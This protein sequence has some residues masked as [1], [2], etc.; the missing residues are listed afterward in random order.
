MAEDRL[1]ESGAPLRLTR[2]AMLRYGVQAGAALGLGALVGC[3]PQ[4]PATPGGPGGESAPPAQPVRT[5]AP[6]AKVAPGAG[7]PRMG[8]R[9]RFG[10]A[11]AGAN[12]VLDSAQFFSGTDWNFG[13]NL[14]DT[15]TEFDAQG[16]VGPGLA[17]SWDSPDPKT[18]VLHLREGVKFH[19]GTP[20]DAEAA[21]F[22][23]D[24]HLNPANKSRQVAQ[25]D[26]IDSV[27]V[28][29]ARTVR[30]HLKRPDADLPVSLA[31]A[32]GMM[33]SP[34]ARQKLGAQ[35]V[36]QPVG[37]GPFVFVEQVRD[38]H[39]LFRRN[40]Q[41][42]RKDGPY[43]DE[44]YHPIILDKVVRF[45]AVANG[46]MEFA[47]ARA[48]EV[49]S[50]R[51]GPNVKTQD[52]LDYNCGLF[53]MNLR[54]T[55]FGQNKYL[56]QAMAWALDR[57]GMIET[58]LGGLA[59][60]ATQLHPP[61]SFWYSKQ[62]QPYGYDPAR[63]RELLKQGGKPNGFK[64]K[65]SGPFGTP[66]V[67]AIVQV[68]QDQFAKVGI[69]TEMVSLESAKWLDD[70]YKVNYDVIP[71]I[72]FTGRIGIHDSYSSMFHT[73]GRFNSGARGDKELDQLIEQAV[74]EYD[75][76]KRKTM[77]DE[78]TRRVHDDVLQIF[79]FY[80]NIRLVMDK[81]VQ[82]FTWVPDGKT[83]FRTT[84]LA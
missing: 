1:A 63:A 36:N 22:N 7:E 57:K 74:G 13:Y 34:T 54:D 41:H 50:I 67:G 18:Y 4:A 24:Y 39:V 82:G 60:E 19:D 48:F 5:A 35:F 17:E 46:E 49:P 9:L 21:K 66:E 53:Y 10:V 33:V 44:L 78:I 15:L 40:E 61:F 56:R 47:V 70:L 64:F 65:M 43:L 80:S 26:S 59:V 51:M 31:D 12:P 27:E 58:L 79:V 38:S 62:L 69:E 71:A 20:F 23:L 45:G 3:G 16:N 68:F 84:W 30:I 76:A 55:V 2:R 52:V 8:G 37:S 6:A 29:N 83:R 42:W 81:K 77:Y 28:V 14:Y 25:V 11:T 72:T 73:K 32:A 75:R